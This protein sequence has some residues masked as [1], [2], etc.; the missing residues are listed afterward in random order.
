MRGAKFKGDVCGK[1]FFTHRVVSTRSVLAG[2]V[3]EADTIVAFQRLLV[4]HRRYESCAG[5]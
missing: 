5:R 4:G 3:V 1:Y 2:L